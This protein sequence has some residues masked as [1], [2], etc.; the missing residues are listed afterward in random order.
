VHTL[1]A[2]LLTTSMVAGLAG[3]GD[4]LRGRSGGD[5]WVRGWT[6]LWWVVALGGQVAGPWP[7]VVAGFAALAVGCVRAALHLRKPVGTLVAYALAAVGG[8]LLWLTP[9]FFYD[10]LVYHLGLPWSWLTNGSFGTVT[11]NTFSHFP[12]AGQ[13]VFLLPVGLGLPEAAAGLHWITFLVTLVALARVAANLGAGRWR[14]LA[15]ALFVGCWHAP[16]IAGLAAVDHLVVLGVVVSVQLLTEP[17]RDGGVDW[18]GVGAAWGLAL[19]AKYQAALPVAAVCVAALMLCA[20]ERLRL[21]VAGALAL[22]VSSFWWIRNVV[23]TGNPVFPLLWSVLGGSGWSLRDEVR[24]QALVREGVQGGTLQAALARLVVPPDGIGWWFLLAV[25][26]AL[27]AL[28][29]RG[30]GELRVRLV[31]GAVALASAAWFFSSQT[32]RYALPVAALMAAL[33]AAGVAGLGRWP[34][35]VAVCG[36]ALTLVHG[37]LTLGVFLTGTLRLGELRAGTVTAESWREGLTVDDPMPAYRACG[38]LL[39]AD[40]RVLVVGEGRSWG[41]PRPHHASSPYDTQLAQELAES[42]PDAATVAAR[43]RGAGF[44]H[45]LISWSELERLS[46]PDYRVMRFEDPR[47]AGRWRSFLS[48]CTSP[49]WRDGSLEIRALRTGCAA[50]PGHDAE[51]PNR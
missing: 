4:V 47:A 45:L 31:G 3:L 49:L 38:R 15:P 30:E 33:A 8:A 36:L 32:T 7:A 46:G 42:A 18:V 25:P 29:R 24:Y 51:V 39:P 14:W 5:R 41:C 40:A 17:H 44:T 10:A 6:L 13:T 1:A 2:L 9:P 43:V 21:L 22:G 12:L 34:A 35:R 26:L 48:S 50:A 23:E 27:A 11:H 19:A 28:L 37:V 16:W 20:R